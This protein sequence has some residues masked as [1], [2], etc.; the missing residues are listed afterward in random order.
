MGGGGWGGVGGGGGLGSLA[1]DSPAWGAR[2]SKFLN[3]DIDMTL[4][5]EMGRT[6]MASDSFSSEI[7][8]ES[9]PSS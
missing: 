4:D 3:G 2:R 8:T 9:A 1:M 6:N 5:I 7:L